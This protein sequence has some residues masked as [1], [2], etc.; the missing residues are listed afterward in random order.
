MPK[1]RMDALD[2][3]GF[4]WYSHDEAWETMYAELKKFQESHGHCNVPF[5]GKLGNTQRTLYNNRGEMTEERFQKLQELGFTWVVRGGDWLAMFANLKKFQ[6]MHGHCRVPKADGKLSSWVSRQRSAHN[7]GKLIEERYQKLQELGFTWTP[8]TSYA[9]PLGEDWLAMFASLKEFQ[10]R[11]GKLNEERFQKLQELRFTWA[12]HGDSSSHV[13]HSNGQ[14]TRSQS[15]R[16]DGAAGQ[17]RK[18]VADDSDDSDL[19]DDD[20]DDDEEEEMRDIELTKGEGESEEEPTSDEEMISKPPAKKLKGATKFRG[21]KLQACTRKKNP[22]R[23]KNAAKE[24]RTKSICDDNVASRGTIA[25]TLD[26]ESDKDDNQGYSTENEVSSEEDNGDSDCEEKEDR[27]EEEEDLHY[28]GS[29]QPASRRAK[30]SQSKTE[31]RKLRKLVAAQETVIKYQIER[32]HHK[33]AIIH[34]QRRAIKKQKRMISMKQKSI[35]E[36]PNQLAARQ[37]QV[38]TIQKELADLQS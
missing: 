37:Q 17:K 7:K 22:A 26:Q 11:H 30:G 33:K 36:L 16:K 18:I 1:D 10:E 29:N 32:L 25:T 23:T 27:G 34:S 24:G 13:T 14:S 6:E 12:V 20:D 28:E 38:D 5:S 31:L 15:S 3:I 9:D 4:C 8:K 19:G 2:D 21:R 35:Q